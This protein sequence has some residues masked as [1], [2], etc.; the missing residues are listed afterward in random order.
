MLD[1]LI[2]ILRAS[3]ADAWEVTDT[4]RI[5]WEFYFIRHKLD[6]NRFTDTEAY[7][8]KVYRKINEGKFL[9]S[10]QADISTT[11][12]EEE[13]RRIVDGLCQDARYV[14]NPAYT[15]NKPV[16]QAPVPET[17]VDVKAISRDFLQALSSLPE[18]ATEDLN[19]Y[20]IFVSEIRRRFINSEGVDVTA[21]YPSSTVEAVVNARRDGHEIELYRFYRSGACDAQQ[22]S[23]DLS[24]T[25]RYGRDKLI[26]GETPALGTAD[27]VLSTDAA[28]EVYDYFISRMSAALIYRRISSWEIGK[29]IAE[30]FSGDKVTVRALKELPNSS[31]NGAYDAEGAP[32]RDLLI[33][34]AGV[35]VHYFG[36]RQFSQYMGLE[37]SFIP[38]NFE[39]TGGTLSA[40]ELRQGAF[41]EVVEFSDFQVSVLN[42]DIAGEIRLAYWHDGKGNVTAVSGG[43]V[44]GSLSDLLSDMRFSKESRQYNN[45]RIPA[46]T[47]LN[48]ATVTGIAGA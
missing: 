8:V 16:S 37:D 40:D 6:Q 10:A 43:S 41:L 15:L 26:A 29:P 30:Q 3:G 38:G 42:G 11:A 14:L 28:T 23:R 24:E 22:L 35:P 25:L 48:G 13:I 33:M 19:S 18:T 39:V 9:G 46:V 7:T 45:L 20:E 4:H 17:P 5:G 1:K 12:S 2:E 47:R 34:D 44:S 21:V 32:V 36:S 27:V 31:S